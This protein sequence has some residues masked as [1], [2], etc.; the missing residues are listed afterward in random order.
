MGRPIDPLQAPAALQLILYQMIFAF[1]AP[2]RRIGLDTRNHALQIAG[3]SVIIRGA[4]VCSSAG[5]A[6]HSHCRGQRFEPAQIHQS[7]PLEDGFFHRRDPIYLPS[8][9]LP[10]A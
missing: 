6:L 7:R 2:L 3:T 10:P 1:S 9:P 8:K 5:R 4:W